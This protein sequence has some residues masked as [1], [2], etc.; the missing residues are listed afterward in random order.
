MASDSSASSSLAP[1]KHWWN[2]FRA[3]FMRGNVVDLAVGVMIGASFGK[4]V[5][6]LVA[7]LITP[8][9]GLLMGRVKF[10]ELKFVIG[11]PPEAPVTI[12]YGNF[13]QVLLDFLL[14]ALVLFILI[15]AVNRLQRKPPPPDAPKPVPTADQQLLAEIRDELRKQNR[16]PVV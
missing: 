6:S 10:S 3:F 15:S 16:T 2:D 9:L 12:N 7:D 11:G 1:V 14:I 13:L 8:P 4:I 5:S